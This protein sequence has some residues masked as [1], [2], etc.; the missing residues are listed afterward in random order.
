[1]P[2]PTGRPYVPDRGAAGVLDGVRVVELADERAEY[3]G[4]LLAGMGAEVI[5][6]EPPMGSA[7]RTVGPFVADIAGPDRSLFFAAHNRSKLSVSV[8]VDDPTQRTALAELIGS[9]D[10]FLESTDIGF[11]DDRGLS[12][13]ALTARFP[14][15]IVARMTAFGD[16]GPWSG[17]KGSDLVHLALGGP[18]MNCG[19]DPVPNGHYDIPPIAP[20]LWHSMVIAGEQLAIGILA[21]LVH[22]GR[23]GQGQTV[24]CAIHEAVAKSTE[25]DLMNWVMRRAPMYRQT[26]R[27]AAEKVSALPTISQTKDGRWILIM[28]VGAKDHDRIHEFLAHYG[29]T[30]E[31]PAVGGEQQ[32]G[33]SIP[34]SSRQSARD[35]R[36]IEHVQRLTRKFSY[37]NFPWHEAQQAGI[38]CSPL[39]KPH[40]NVADPHWAARGTFAQIA[41]P[42]VGV[43]LTYPVR[44]WLSTEPAWRI[45]DRA[46]RIGEHTTRIWTDLARASPRAPVDE[47]A[48]A[49]L[50]LRPP[51]H[52]PMPLEGVRVLDFTWF[53]ASAGGTRFLAAFGAECIKVEW[54]ANPDTRIAAMAPVGGRAARDAATEPLP[55]VTDPDMGGQFNNKNP[56]KRGLSLNVRHPRGLEI[57]RRLVA[58]SDIVAE[59]FSPG[60]MDRWGLG[61]EQLQEIRPDIIYAQQSG[62]GTIGEYGRYRAVGPIAAALSGISEMSGLPEPAMPAGWG[63]SYLDWIGAYSF[64]VA[65]LAALHHRDRTGRGQWIDASQTESGI[66]A[67]N[68]AILDWSSNGRPWSRTGNAPADGSA[69][70]QGAYPCLGEDRWLA[71]SCRTDGERQALAQVIGLNDFVS[72]R[73]TGIAAHDEGVDDCDRQISE[74]TRRHEPYDAMYQMQAAGVPA[75]VCQDAGDRCDTD[76]QLAHLDWLTE[77]TGTKIGRWPVAN[78]AS[79]LSATPA[80]IGGVLDRGA[81]CYGEDN[82]WVLG[83]LLGFGRREIADLKADGVI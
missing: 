37:D 18:M 10:I 32:Q 77:V 6:V 68:G 25:L 12:H 29:V 67:A 13:A 22:Q 46:P 23:T 65:M 40:E 56:G 21:A 27:H 1:M 82:E 71:I 53:L 16:T 64:A 75:G 83:E 72:Q 39:R 69:F 44:K 76:P 59:G 9:A 4:L 78:V 31:E 55:G 63:Y 36:L 58:V 7:T 51:H 17:F 60:V 52:K 28:P 33:R 45:G 8:D 54:K 34:G 61:Y 15:L 74:W 66:F 48:L 30:A 38:A 42:E 3:A 70:P 73:S 43:T 81:P 62:M 79:K 26:C 20:Q 5:K 11:L 24:T 14:H 49:A 47:S 19:Y 50:P 35:V 57:A 2:T 41:H 80:H